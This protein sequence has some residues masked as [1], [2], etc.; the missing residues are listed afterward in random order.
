MHFY[1]MN[2]IEENDS[3][4]KS[5]LKLWENTDNNIWLEVGYFDQEDP[6]STHGIALTQ[7][8]A[9]AL[10]KELTRLVGYVPTS[11]IKAPAQEIQKPEGKQL[12]IDP[13]PTLPSRV[14][15]GKVS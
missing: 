11:Q 1:T 8:D 10:I 15:W 12:T 5:E 13:A 7:S 4:Y 3:E 6:Y 14:N 2:I 9:V